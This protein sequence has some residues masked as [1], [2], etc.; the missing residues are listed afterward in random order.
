MSYWIVFSFVFASYVIR[1][2]FISERKKRVSPLGKLL[3]RL[4]AAYAERTGRDLE[5]GERRDSR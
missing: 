2:G 1:E 5:S 3:R 4:W